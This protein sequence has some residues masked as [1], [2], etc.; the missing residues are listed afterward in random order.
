MGKTDLEVLVGILL[1]V[2]IAG[3]TKDWWQPAIE[4]L[5]KSV[6][7]QLQRLLGP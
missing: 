5:G 1:T 6:S 2:G 7:M 3:A 4:S